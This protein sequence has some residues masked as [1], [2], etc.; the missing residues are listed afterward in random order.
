MLKWIDSKISILGSDWLFFVLMTS[1]I[2]SCFLRF[3][4][5]HSCV[6]STSHVVRWELREIHNFAPKFREFTTS[7]RLRHVVGQH[8]VGWTVLDLDFLVFDETSNIEILDV[9]MASA[10]A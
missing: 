3:P 2:F 5:T 4:P 6:Q 8:E 10:L 9:E 7:E 1:H